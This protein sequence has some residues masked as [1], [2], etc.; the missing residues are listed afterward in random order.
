VIDGQYIRVSLV[1]T[2]LCAAIL[3][4]LPGEVRAD[5]IPAKLLF[6]GKP[7]PADTKPQA[8]GFYTR[9][10]I[11]GA[12]AIPVDG[13]DWQVMRLSRN[14]RWGH[15]ALIS[16]LEDLSRKAKADGWN[17]LMIGDISQP[18][19][20][21][22]LTGHS[23]HQ[24]GLDAD[25]WFM[26]M[27]DERLTYKQRE[28]L[29]ATSVLQEGSVYVDDSRWTSSHTSLLRRAAN[30]D[31]VQRVLVHPGVKKKLCDTVTGDRAWLAKIRPSYGHHYH[32]H[33]RLHCPKG[34]PDCQPQGAVPRSTGCDGSLQ[35][36]FDVALQPKKP[37]PEKE[38]ETRRETALSDLPGACAAILQAK[39]VEPAEAE[40]KIEASAF[41]AP[42]IHI[43]AVS[44]LAI[45]A[46][47]PIETGN[48]TG[49]RTAPGSAPGPDTVP[50]PTPR[51]RR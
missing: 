23:S 2:L 10:C 34:S 43:P 21:P 14:R 9:G 24:V 22:M 5:P 25:L 38:L 42:P 29:S 50:V 31:R 36:W 32:F 41:T 37:E 19:G 30:N 4:L 45:L 13:P 18:R 15:P 47:K 7:L 49:R 46:S 20:G 11:G 51:P 44:A 17:G 12:V 6:G 35:W 27:P 1:A 26:P 40:F 8:I 16:I 39:P 28:E 3:P 33:I 48:P